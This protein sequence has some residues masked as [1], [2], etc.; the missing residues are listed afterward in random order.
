MNM[1]PQTA[2]MQTSATKT[3]SAEL[4]EVRPSGLRVIDK[5]PSTGSGLTDS[6]IRG[7]LVVKPRSTQTASNTTKTTT[8]TVSTE[9][10]EVR[11]SAAHNRSLLVEA[12][13]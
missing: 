7:G 13:V 6:F 4:V 12:M 1:S 9:L 11:L 10:V 2:N 8:K 3:V 5:R